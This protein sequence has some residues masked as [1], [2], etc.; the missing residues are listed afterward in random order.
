MKAVGIK[1]LKDRLSEYVKLAGAG[2]T[3]L[4]TDRDE[5][6]AELVPP[7][8][9]RATTVADAVLAD[10][11]RAGVLSPA[12]SPGAPLPARDPVLRLQALLDMLADDRADR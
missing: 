7:S 1:V 5:V 3:I 2:E 11:I 10:L 9:S 8:A 4:V 12:T 6:V